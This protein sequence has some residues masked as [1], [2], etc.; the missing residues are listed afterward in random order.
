MVD[1]ATY[2]LKGADGTSDEYFQVIERFTDEWLIHARK[3]VGSLV[4]N[5]VDMQRR[6]QKTVRSV[7]HSAFE[8]LVLAVTMREHGFDATRLP[9]W[10]V[11]ILRSLLRAQEQHPRLEKPFKWL[12]GVASG[13]AGGIGKASLRLLGER[14]LRFV[15]S[16]D[17]VGQVVTW[18]LAQGQDTQA[19]RLTAWKEY[20]DSLSF[21]AARDAIARAQCLADDFDRM[22][23]ARLG[24]Y[25]QKVETYLTQTAPETRWRYD[26]ALITRSRVEYHLGML[27]TEVLNRDY[28]SRFIGTG[29]RLVILPTCLRAKTDEH[30]QAQQ[31]PMGRICQGCTPACRVWQISQL[32]AKQ[33]VPVVVIP[34]DELA[35]VC[36]SSGS[37]GSGMGVVGL[38][39]ALTNWNAGWEAEQ[40]GLHA[41]GVLLDCAGCQKHWTREGLSTDANLRQIQT[42]LGMQSGAE[43]GVGL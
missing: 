11:G 7:D 18:L 25:T 28:R 31:T 5:Y 22:S 36:V 39:C 30:C 43:F 17:A 12:R 14:S 40:L 1:A 21:L 2:S 37:A 41:Q 38:S 15:G 32:G 13:L 35:R 9:D 19:Q 8:L 24:A 23:E 16:R 42:V 27:G 20:F 34:D 26:G 4:E 10:M 3:T 29:R 33:G 6:N